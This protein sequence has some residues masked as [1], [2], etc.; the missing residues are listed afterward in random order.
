MS[1]YAAPIRVLQTDFR[2]GQIDR[3]LAMRVDSK[4]Y[5]SG[6]R[7]L[8]NMLLRSTGAADRRPGGT[9]LAV[10]NQRSRLVEFEYDADEKYIFAFGATHLRIYNPDGTTATTFTGSTDCPWDADEVWELT[11]TQL[12]DV[13]FVAHGDIP[14]QKIT[15]TGASTFTVDEYDFDSSS[16]GTV[17]QPHYKFETPATTLAIS[18]TAIGAGRTLTSSPGIFSAAWVGDRVRIFG[19]EIEITGYT[20]ATT[21]T[22][23]VHQTVRKK[24]DANPLRSTDLSGVVE[25]THPFHGLSNG[26]TITFE[27]IS[28]NSPDPGITEG[29]Q[30]GARTITVVDDDHYTFT[31]GGG[32]VASKSI[33]FGGTSVNVYTTAGTREWTEQ[34]F[35]ARRGYPSA[36]G[37]HENRLWMGGTDSAQTLLVGSVVGE[38][39][40]FDV[41][42]GE[43]ADSIQAIL[44]TYR[45]G[46]IRHIVSSRQ[47]QVFTETGEVIIETAQ[48]EPITPGGLRIR[49]DTNYGSGN[50]R[51]LPFDGATLFLQRNGKNLRE[52]IFD[53]NASAFASP[54]VSAAASDL[55]KDPHDMAVLYGGTSRPEQY[56]FIVNS[57]GTMAC[58]H[59][60]RN[61]D[62]AA[63][64]PFETFGSHTFD[65]VVVIGSTVYFSIKRGSAY[66]LDRFELDSEDIWLDGAKSMGPVAATVTWALG[67][68]Y[69]NATVSVMSNGHYIGD[70]TANGAGTITLLDP[71]TSI[72]AGYDPEIEIIPMPPD[73]EIN[74]GPLTGEIRRIVSITAHF[75]ETVN[76]TVNGKP[77]IGLSIGDD[78]SEPPTE[79]T[80]KKRFRLFGY[81]RDPDFA[82]AQNAPGKLTL[83]GF[84]TEVSI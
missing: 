80:G 10:L 39:F 53:F 78:L 52:L 31:A 59:S 14:V 50:V 19:Q 51:P 73:K 25:V 43:D 77:W 40:N 83:L 33:D 15:R 44:S 69:A 38:Y 2:S 67:S 48:G 74:D 49:A 76:A 84:S 5:P 45:S 12:G 27:G 18:N 9:T 23:T 1:N 26:A 70:Y 79:F 64:T 55:I 81:N 36:I 56:A 30:N 3:T 8:K 54:S 24:L 57:D 75:H 11:F 20:N 58:F 82:I 72:V 71:V 66:H 60:V 21:V 13:T 41:G 46:R 28:T 7:S 34:A 6:A 32:D 16:N 47:L 65:S 37:F 22:A 29:N 17:R 61:E 35:S 63:L 62:L 4:A 68:N 42:D